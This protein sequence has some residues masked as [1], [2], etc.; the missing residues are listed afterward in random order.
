[1]YSSRVVH[2]QHTDNYYCGMVKATSS[3]DR[4][5]RSLSTYRYR[6]LAGSLVYKQQHHSL[7]GVGDG[8]RLV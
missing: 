2:V 5:Y 4:V 6:S 3:L 1:M 8:V 7:T